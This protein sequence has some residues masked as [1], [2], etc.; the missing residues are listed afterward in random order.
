MN[1][2]Q[3]TWM[4]ATA[5]VGLIVLGINLSLL[6]GL[7]VLICWGVE[8]VMLGRLGQLGVVMALLLGS[9]F[10]MTWVAI[11]MDELARVDE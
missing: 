11:Y 10:L 4:I 6:A 8:S 7:V 5:L 1:A 3:L 9:L 2:Q